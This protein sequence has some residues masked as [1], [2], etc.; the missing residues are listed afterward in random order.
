MEGLEI[1]KRAGFD[2]AEMKV[3]VLEPEEAESKFASTFRQIEDVGLPVE[4]FNVFIPGTLPM[5]GDNVEPE[6]LDRYLDVAIARMGELGARVVVF[7]SGGA[8]STPPGFNQDEAMDQ[9]SEFLQTVGGKLEGTNITLAIEP[10][11]KPAS[12][13]INSVQDALKMARRVN[14]PRIRVLADLFHMAH[15]DDGME[16]LI[17]AGGALR[18][19][20]VPVPQLSG[21]SQ[22]PWDSLYSAFL[23]N[24]R[25]AKY[26]AR[27]SI[28]DNG[29]RFQHL[30]S[31]AKMA[32][33]YLKE[34]WAV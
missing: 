4:A 18:H 29:G 26:E 19:V 1:V 34:G 20:H 2:Y 12:D 15:E 33:D 5:V 30:E 17:D 24:L 6:R 16:N 28:E 25:L 31:E 7:G 23:T 10:L 21:M 11:Y 3:G 8:R 13:N 27:I 9:I 22:R 32:L 14:H